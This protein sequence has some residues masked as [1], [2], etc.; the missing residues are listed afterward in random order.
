MCTQTWIGY[1]LLRMTR[2]RY[3][4]ELSR[5]YYYVHIHFAVR[6]MFIFANENFGLLFFTVS[7]HDLCVQ[8]CQ[9]W[10]P[11]N[12]KRIVTNWLRE[13]DSKTRYVWLTK[14]VRLLEMHNC[15]LRTMCCSTQ[16]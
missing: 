12:W 8:L 16:A 11:S 5:G 10:L 15:M 9:I 1:R 13:G 2:E 4:G 6:M 7:F 3:T 14:G